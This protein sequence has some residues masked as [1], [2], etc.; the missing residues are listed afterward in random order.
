[1]STSSI[2]HI[3]I[4][5]RSPSSW[6]FIILSFLRSAPSRSLCFGGRWRERDK[7]ERQHLMLKRELLPCRA[8]LCV[9]FCVLVVNSQPQNSLL[10]HG[11]VGNSLSVRETKAKR[12][13]YLAKLFKINYRRSADRLGLQSKSLF[14]KFNVWLRRMLAKFCAHH[15]KVL[16]KL[17][18]QS[19]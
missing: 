15:A 7:C 3:L 1:M 9:F 11:R 12:R 4:F 8:F 17:S 6:Y 13:V 16:F 5:F 18:K 19:D 10:R 14:I 2:L